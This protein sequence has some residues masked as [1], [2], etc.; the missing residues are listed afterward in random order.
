MKAVGN[1]FES[2]GTPLFNAGQLELDTR[3]QFG[4]YDIAHAHRA[5]RKGESVGKITRAT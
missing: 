5:M 1:D 3:E 2:T 4:I